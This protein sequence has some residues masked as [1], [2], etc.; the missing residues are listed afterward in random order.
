MKDILVSETKSIID[1]NADAEIKP[2][3]SFYEGHDVSVTVWDPRDGRLIMY[4]LERL[5][6][7]KHHY[8]RYIAK[9]DAMAH[10]FKDK[11]KYLD[12]T[13]SMNLRQRNE[14]RAKNTGYILKILANLK[15]DFG[16]E[17]DFECFAYKPTYL[18]EMPFNTFNFN[19]NVIKAK[20]LRIVNITHHEAHVWSAY[21]QAPF[22][23]SAIISWDSGGDFTTFAFG[24]IDNCQPTEMS[25]YPTIRFSTMWDI[26]TEHFKCIKGTGNLL[27]FAG[28]V[29]GLSAYGK[30]YAKEAE[31]HID[32]I[33]SWC[34]DFDCAQFDW[35]N[36]ARKEVDEWL[37]NDL[38]KGP[39]ALEG[40][41]EMIAAYALQQATERGIVK[42]IQ[43]RFIDKIREND[44]N[45][46]ITGGTAM[47]ILANEAIKK[48]FPDIN[49]FVQSNP[50]DDNISL[51]MLSWE[52]A[53][54]GKMREWA[55]EGKFDTKYA[56]PYLFDHEQFPVWKNSAYRGRCKP[57]TLKEMAALLKE[58]KIIGFAHGRSEVGPRALGNRSILC[59]PSIK[60]MKDTLNDKVKHREPF[61]P[62]APMCKLED[63]P[64]YFNS[65]DFHMMDSMQ[66]AV[67][68][69]DEWKD[70]LTEITHVDGTARVQVVTK[71][72]NPVVYELLDHFDGVLLN[73]SFNV[74]GNPI[75]N[76]L[77]EAFR[78]LENTELDYVVTEDKRDGKFWIFS[79]EKM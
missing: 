79:K 22:H 77:K 50:A 47:N 24:T 41:N 70:V 68:V 13:G 9:E 8:V 76:T 18:Q 62:F 59:D 60:G 2:Y 37:L 43:E 16:I 17:N 23:K 38:N 45:L 66:F 52:T 11:E 55:Y 5:S 10:R 3:I 53:Y 57:I 58:G 15:K 61:R 67:E 7:V 34:V 32:K 36:Q 56:G 29:M 42:V 75:L 78:V 20:F 69:K 19:I 64:K 31:Q 14:M 46:C 51:G 54:S 44:N 21:L 48:A 30:E 63:A 27:D 72:S 35:K 6:G 28:K 1:L 39:S 26:I 12:R 65:R 74:Q 33:M 71:E 25:Q 4:P 40:K 73:T 49:V